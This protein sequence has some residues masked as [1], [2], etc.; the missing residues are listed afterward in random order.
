[1]FFKSKEDLATFAV[2]Y[3]LTNNEIPQVKK[4]DVDKNL[5]EKAACFV[6]IY[7]DNKLQGCVG[8]YV[9]YEPLY[10]N[11]INNA[12]NAAFSDLRFLPVQKEDLAKLKTEVSVLTP[13]CDYKP[14]DTKEL[15]QFLQKEKPGLII[16]KDGRKT[17]FLPQV[18]DDL[19][20][21]A[22]FLSHLCLKAG[23]AA[24]AWQE[25]DMQY[26]V[27]YKREQ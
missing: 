13:I 27:F 15:L 23:I 21:P 26:W 16:E 14:K 8:N 19:P 3:F 20:N 5:W 12:V 18:W 9:A 10:Q 1:M 4:E 25:K 7:V 6:T 11:I 17:L 24:N 2:A 22:D